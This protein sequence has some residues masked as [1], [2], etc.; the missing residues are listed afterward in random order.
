MNCE[1]MIV[2]ISGHLDGVNTSEEEHLLQEHLN[3]CASCRELLADFQKTEALLKEQEMTVP[4]S[5]CADVMS[6]IREETR[7]KKRNFRLWSTLGVSA[8]A[9]ALVLGAGALTM[10]QMGKSAPMEAQTEMEET[11]EE[12]AAR[13]ICDMAETPAE[14]PMTAY[15]V[16]EA[17]AVYPQEVADRL[18]GVVVCFDHD[19]EELNAY[20][21]ETDVDGNVI[22][23]LADA[24]E[25]AELG[26][27]YDGVL[28]LPAEALNECA[29][30]IVI[31]E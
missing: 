5:V 23:L 4:E 17:S 15:S 20:A 29:Y 22:Y 16:S 30:A 12:S 18:G 13:V 25:A 27:A 21:A 9:V 14:A 6:K 10:P 2:L 8:A 24:E 19:V 28:Y 11:V 3:A 7:R 31:G 26:Q 1:D